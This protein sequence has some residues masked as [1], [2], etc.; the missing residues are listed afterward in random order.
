MLDLQAGYNA[1]VRWNVGVLSGAH[2]RERLVQEPHTHL[3]GSV[4]DLSSRVLGW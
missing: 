1:R 4:S 3:I 2:Q